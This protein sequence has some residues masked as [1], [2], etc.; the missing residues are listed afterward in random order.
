MFIQDDPQRQVIFILNVDENHWITVTNYSFVATEAQVESSWYIYDSLNKISYEGQLSK[1]FKKMYPLKNSMKVSFV[2][3]FRQHGGNDCGLFSLAYIQ[4][5]V[6]G[7][8]PAYIHYD[9]L[10]MR[11]IY[12]YFISNKILLSFPSETYQV[13]K[14][15]TQFCFNLN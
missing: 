9:Q 11:K 14:K 5:M 15:V 8:D 1:F 4:S 6:Y 3:V 12:N 7:L 13:T 2:N 10:E